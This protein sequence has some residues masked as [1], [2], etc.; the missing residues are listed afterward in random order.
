MSVVTNEAQLL[1]LI[2]RFLEKCFGHRD[3]SR[4]LSSKQQSDTL[5]FSPWFF[6]ENF[7][8]L[9]SLLESSLAVSQ[10]RLER[11]ANYGTSGGNEKAG[12]AAIVFC[13]PQATLTIPCNAVSTFEVVTLLRT[14]PFYLHCVGVKSFTENGIQK[15]ELPRSWLQFFWAPFTKYPA[16]TIKDYLKLVAEKQKIDWLEF[17]PSN[18]LLAASE[19]DESEQESKVVNAGAPEGKPRVPTPTP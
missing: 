7:F 11:V 6:S 15:V 17:M 1:L 13:S 5:P 14:S 3:N 18:V 2:E 19:S 12:L 16:Y 9:A 8:L 4:F 10:F